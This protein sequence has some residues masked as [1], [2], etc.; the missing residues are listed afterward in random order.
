MKTERVL[1][2]INSNEIDLLKELLEQEI[3]K[4][5]L[6]SDDLTHQNAMKRYYK[7]KSKFDKPMCQAPTKVIYDNQEYYCFFDGFTLVLTKNICPDIQLH[8]GDILDFKT[9]INGCK[10]GTTFSTDINQLI[11]AA[12]TLGY[13]YKKSELEKANYIGKF[14]KTH[15]NIAYLEKAFSII[16]DGKLTEVTYSKEHSPI[17][18]KTS[19]GYAL[20][21]PMRI[22]EDDT[23]K[24]IV[25]AI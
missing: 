3:Y 11:T 5:S 6:S 1:E 2:M 21:S 19:I 4:K 14:V 25:S 7:F 16:N 9:L 17:L 18:I 23:D 20:V 12:K 24:H 10:N 8:I 22:T 13:T 15:V